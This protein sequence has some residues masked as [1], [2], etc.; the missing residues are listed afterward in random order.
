MTPFQTCWS[1]FYSGSGRIFHNHTQA[2]LLALS[3]TKGL[4]FHRVWG[5]GL[6]SWS[7]NLPLDDVLHMAR[8]SEF[9]RVML[10]KVVSRSHDGC[11]AHDQASYSSTL[12]PPF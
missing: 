10:C 3:R 9:D 7:N 12:S 1:I 4:I 8:A 6:G 2:A 5:L 11:D